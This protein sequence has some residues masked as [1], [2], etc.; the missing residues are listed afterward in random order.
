[1]KNV[2]K[3]CF[4]NTMVEDANIEQVCNF[5]YFGSNISADGTLDKDLNSRICKISVSFISLCNVW[6]NCKI[7]TQRFELMEQLH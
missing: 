7:L 6:Y 3:F 1:M 4:L 2:D 5:T